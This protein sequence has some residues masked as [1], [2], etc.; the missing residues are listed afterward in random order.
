[1]MVL[2]KVDALANRRRDALMATLMKDS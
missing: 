2:G 1:M